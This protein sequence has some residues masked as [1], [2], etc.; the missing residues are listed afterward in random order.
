MF[1]MMMLRGLSLVGVVVAQDVD[2]AQFVNP[3]IGSEGAISG[4]ACKLT[5]TKITFGNVTNKQ[6]SEVA[7]SLWAVQCRL[8]WS[9]WASTHMKSLSTKVR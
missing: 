9:S 6:Q 7:M 1:A 2:Y 8:V 5:S 3:F 4:Y